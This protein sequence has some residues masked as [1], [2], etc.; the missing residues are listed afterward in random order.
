MTVDHPFQLK[1]NATFFRLSLPIFL[2]LVAEPVTGLVDTAFVAR[3]GDDALAALGMASTFLSHVLW[4]VFFL[5]VGAQTEIATL[6]GTGRDEDI[7]TLTRVAT[8]L[9]IACGVI[10]SVVLFPLLPAAASFMGA[11]DAVYSDGLLYLRI[12]LVGAPAAVL[13]MTFFGVLRGLHDMKTPLVVAV[14]TNLLNVV[15]DWVLIFGYGPVP[16]FG[17]AGAAWASAVSQWVGVFLCAFALRPYISFSG[18][19]PLEVVQR[20]LL[21]GRDMFLR[22]GVL[23]LFLILATRVATRLG[24]EA[25]AAHEV[26]RKFWLFNALFLDAFA[27]TAQSLIAYFIGIGALSTARRVARV[28]VGWG[29]V[30]GVVIAVVMVVSLNVVAEAFALDNVTRDLFVGAWIVCALFEPL[31]AVSFVTDGVHWGTRDYAYLRNAM[32]LATGISVG[33]LAL[34][35]LLAVESLLEVWLMIGLWIV[36]RTIVGVIRIWPGIG[37]APLRETG[38]RTITP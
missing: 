34:A 6:L 31:C 15:L 2:S 7:R 3:I 30:T 24:P 37:N 27:M 12:R 36:L 13:M 8:H 9:G 5:G 21:V 23:S 11:T 32:F 35:E 25:G 26:V 10:V 28:G 4:I 17:I 22:T 18:R 14:V 33:C 1:P 20:L 29:V 16:A 19:L 38:K